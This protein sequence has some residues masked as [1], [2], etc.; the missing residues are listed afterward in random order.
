MAW[1]HISALKSVPGKPEIKILS[2]SQIKGGGFAA[3]RSIN[4]G[5]APPANGSALVR[6]FLKEQRRAKSRGTR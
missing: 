4:V 1:F 6:K 5:S 2:R 3:G